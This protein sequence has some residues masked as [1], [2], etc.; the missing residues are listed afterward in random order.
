M[1]KIRYGVIGL[2]NMGSMHS[3]QIVAEGG[4]HCRLT[5]V[6]DI[7]EEKAKAFG[8]ELSVPYFTDGQ[9]MYDSGLID[10]VVI[11]V[12]HYW[13][14][15]L[16]IR[17][18][19]KKIHVLCEKPM[20]SRIGIA[21]A[22]R[23]EC[24]KHKVKLGLVF[25]H[26]TRGDMQKI[27][28]IVESGQLGEVYRV[29]MV[30]STWFRSQAYYNSGDWR[31]TWDGEGGGIL[32]NQAPHHLDLFGWIGGKPSRVTAVLDTRDHDI[33]VEDTANVIC[34]FPGGKNGYIY[35]S[36]AEQP[37]KE[38]FVI[39][40]EKATLVLEDG[41][42]R[43]GKLKYSL[44]DQIYGMKS[45]SVVGAAKAK[46]TCTWKDVPLPKRGKGW[47]SHIELIRQF[48]KHILTG[49]EQYAP[50]EAGINEL[51]LSNAAYISGF[52]NKRVD[53][54][55]SGREIDLLIK[56]LEKDRST[57]RGGGMRAEADKDL[58]R[59]GVKPL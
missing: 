35:S 54:P 2:G 8:E 31:G 20:E 19:R 43:L 15:P 12:P 30:C 10:A 49:A 18:A 23:A 6:C 59:L 46:Q 37:G 28:R 34:E 17:A 45:Q 13:H 57:G 40:G 56:K 3:R 47:G 14:G 44:K 27:K 11:A 24:K 1:K 36:T 29:E 55:V 58:K 32:I 41:K 22:M 51:E 16:T 26:R 21:R 53:M 5:A 42:I 38:R 39:T 9:A 33:E 50:A 4:R 52:K 7:V 25:H 48:A